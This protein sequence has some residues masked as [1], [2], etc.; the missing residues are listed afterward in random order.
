MVENP[1]IA[2]RCAPAPCSPLV[3]TAAPPPRDN[4]RRSAAAA[5]LWLVRWRRSRVRGGARD[6]RDG[7]SLVLKQGDPYAP[8]H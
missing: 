5:V 4:P 7:Y 1:L 6:A 8:R 2:Q 3:A